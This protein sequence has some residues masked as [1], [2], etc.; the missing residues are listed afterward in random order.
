VQGNECGGAF[1]YFTELL[2][3]KGECVGAPLVL[4]EWLEK[5]REPSG[6]DRPETL[7]SLNSFASTTLEA[8]AALPISFATSYRSKSE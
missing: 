8:S 6:G 5:R 4:E 7:Q 2:R 1:A 3:K